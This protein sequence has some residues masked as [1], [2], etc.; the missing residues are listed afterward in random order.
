MASRKPPRPPQRLFHR[1]ARPAIPPGAL[2]V[3]NPP[4]ELKMSEILGDFVDP[5]LAE[6]FSEGDYRGMLRIGVLAWNAA[7]LPP[8]RR[9]GFLAGIAAQEE[10]SLDPAAPIMTE[11]VRDMIARKDELFAAIRRRIISF[12]LTRTDQE[13]RLA[14]A[15][16]PSEDGPL[17][18]GG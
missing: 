1:S 2:V 17:G 12:E 10:Q 14:V 18:S 3:S 6:G 11:L 16:N 8:D 9:A 7:L 15:S 5:Y 4:G 13:Y